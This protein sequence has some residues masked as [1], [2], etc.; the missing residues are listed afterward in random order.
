MSTSTDPVVS[1][2]SLEVHIPSDSRPDF[3]TSGTIAVHI[4]ANT[5]AL[6]LAS[7]TSST[8]HALAGATA[9]TTPIA[10]VAVANASDA[11]FLP[12]PTYVGQ[13][14]TVKNS[15]ASNGGVTYAAGGATI[16]GTA[17][18]TGV[19]LTANAT[20]KYVATSLTAYVTI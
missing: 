4:D 12:L 18:A 6:P 1:T 13:Q 14:Y 9:V 17:G 3:S 2:V 15:N 10:I 5:F 16:N 8:T 19:A 20:T 11:I 7:I